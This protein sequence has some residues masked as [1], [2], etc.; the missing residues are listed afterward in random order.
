M[1]ISK[2]AGRWVLR[3]LDS[4]LDLTVFAAR[5]AG[6]IKGL[7]VRGEQVMDLS[8]A[9]FSKSEDSVEEKRRR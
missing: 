6:V 3:Y 1:N 9:C 2:S 5:M 4:S 8:G 7:V